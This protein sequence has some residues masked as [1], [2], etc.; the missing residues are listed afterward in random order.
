MPVTSSDVNSEGLTFYE[1]VCAAGV[2]VQVHGEIK[3]YS[4]SRSSY[5]STA[6]KRPP[7]YDLVE[8]DSRPALPR[9]LMKRER[10][11][12]VW[13]SKKVREAWRRGEDP[14]EWR[15]Y[16]QRDKHD[17]GQACVHAGNS[18]CQERAHG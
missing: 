16:G 18:R 10:S 11:T 2:A 3:P 4:T 13:Y 7:S 8:L 12:T 17:A 5:V 15:R 14:T 9:H 6:L 1:W